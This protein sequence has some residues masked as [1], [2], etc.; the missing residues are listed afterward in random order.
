MCTGTCRT[1]SQG[2]LTAHAMIKQ[3]SKLDI[4]GI[5]VHVYQLHTLGVYIFG[6]QLFK[7]V[8]RIA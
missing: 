4:N 2:A 3:R 8:A 6:L 7:V 1:M 5:N